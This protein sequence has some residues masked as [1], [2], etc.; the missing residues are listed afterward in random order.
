MYGIY[1]LVTKNKISKKTARII[2][3]VGY[4]LAA[5][6]IIWQF[7]IKGMLFDEYYELGNMELSNKLET[8]FYYVRAIYGDTAINPSALNESF[9]KSA[10]DGFIKLQL[11]IVD[12]LEI[13]LTL[14]STV[15]IATGRMYDIK[16][17]FE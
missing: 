7:V 13:L 3:I 12:I 11:W 2:E 1:L 5:A 14:G 10:G 17:E 4:G 9:F 8:V 16:K 6:F 15:C